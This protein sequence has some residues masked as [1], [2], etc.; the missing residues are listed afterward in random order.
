MNKLIKSK[1]VGFLFLG[2]MLL[3]GAWLYADDLKS[4]EIPAEKIQ[5]FVDIFKK[6]KEQYVDDVD[7]VHDVGDV[8]DVAVSYTHLTLPT[9][10]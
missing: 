2:Y 4:D 3:P 1:L 10:A 7:D 6:V 9:K 8:G 5:Q